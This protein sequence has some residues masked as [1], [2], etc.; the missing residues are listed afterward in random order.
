ML[1]II[2]LGA[3]SLVVILL[4][5]GCKPESRNRGYHS[6]SEKA[7][8]KAQEYAER[9]AKEERERARQRAKYEGRRY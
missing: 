2:I 5:L 6:E 3:V 9:V 7:Q 8:Y 1:E 4:Y